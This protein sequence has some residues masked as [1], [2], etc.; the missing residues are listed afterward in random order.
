LLRPVFNEEENVD[1]LY[2][3]VKATV[4]TIDKYAFE[5]FLLITTLKIT[6][7]QN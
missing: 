6:Q 4:S 1:E 2:R 5:L 3:R 7:L